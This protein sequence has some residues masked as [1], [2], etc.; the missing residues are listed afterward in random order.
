MQ[1]YADESQRARRTSILR[2]CR[3]DCTGERADDIRRWTCLWLNDGA[4]AGPELRLASG[5][6]RA[7]GRSDPHRV[8]AHVAKARREQREVES[9]RQSR[10]W[11]YPTHSRRVTTLRQTAPTNSPLR[12]S[13]RPR[14][15][16]RGRTPAPSPGRTA[17]PPLRAAG[18]SPRDAEPLP[19]W[20]VG[21]H[22]GEGVWHGHQAAQE[23]DI[24]A[25]KLV[26]IAAP[27]PPLVVV[28]NAW[29]RLRQARDGAHDQPAEH[30][31]LLH[32][33]E[34][35]VRERAWFFAESSQ[36]WRFSPDRAANP[37]SGGF[38]RLL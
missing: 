29:Q 3:C 8:R 23:R 6:L 22:R 37:Q 34:L 7:R 9:P 15:P 27:I 28:T 18:R 13:L 2:G 25:G 38:A 36:E 20:P 32:H 33:F 31:M 10:P 35:F 17:S 11:S 5:R 19:V 14:R 24:L 12:P 21:G 26:R 1:Y 16:E 30:R 4:L